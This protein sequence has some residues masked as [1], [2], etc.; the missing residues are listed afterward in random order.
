MLKGRGREIGTLNEL[1]DGVRDG[2]GHALVVRGEAGIGKT[3]LLEWA[4]T[5]AS[6]L[7]VMRATGAEFEMGLP[8]SGLHQLLGPLANRL[9]RLPEPQRDAL[10][11]A[12][13]R[14]SGSA[15]DQL[16]VAMAA[17]TLLSEIA[18]ERPVLC[19]VDD[20]QWL[21]VASGQALAFVARR[22]AAEP[23]G[24]LLGLR[25]P[26]SSTNLAP[27]P[28]LSVEGLADEEARAL[29]ATVIHGPMDERVRDRIISEAR[30]NPL[31]LLELTAGLRPGEMAGEF[32]L[33]VRGGTTDDLFQRRLADLPE[34][35][36]LLLLAAAAEPIGDPVLLWAAVRRLG[37]DV[38]AAA[39]AEDTGLIE[40]DAR[41]RFRHPLVRA[42]VYRSASPSQRRTVHA[43]LAEVTPDSDLDRRAWHQ[44]QASQGPD[45]AVAAGLAASAERA[46]TR[47]GVAAAAAF[48]ERSAQLTPDA[49]PRLER[50]FTAA[51]AKLDAGA[52]DEAETLLS[53]IDETALDQVAFA[54]LEIL[55]GQIAFAVRR[56]MDAPVPLLSAARRLESVNASM[57]REVH[58]DALFAAVIVGGDLTLAVDAAKAA[59]PADGP[60][61]TVDFLLD[62]LTLLLSGDNHGGATLIH[63]A[64]KEGDDAV[65]A[66]RI[67]M[68]P[69]LS[70]EVWDLSPYT[71]I[72][73]RQISNAR[74][75]GALTAL[76]QA[77]V[78][79]GG[80]LLR[81]G[82]LRT[83]ASL[84][85]QG[86]ELVV[87]TGT[88]P[89]YSHLTLAAWTG[90]S[91]TEEQIRVAIEDANVRGEGQM[92]AFAH[93]ALSLY[94]N[95]IGDYQGA[96]AAA[97]YATSHLDL[98]FKGLALRELVEAAVRA[99]APDVAAQA[100]I[101]LQ[102]GT[103]A[104][105]TDWGIG[106]EHL[107][108]ALITQGEKADEHYRT[109]LE[110]MGRSE[111]G[112]D[113]ARA[114]L[115]YGEWL[116]RE[117]RRSDARRVL[118]ASHEELAEMG[119]DGFAHR[120]A[121]EL[122][123]TGERARKRDT[124]T[125]D[126]LTAQEL[127]IARLVSSGS[128]SKEI[129][130]ELFISPR[131]VD[132]HLRNIFRKLSITSRRQLR[133]HSLKESV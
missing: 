36:Q 82:R 25:E 91:T 83:A 84:L 100:F 101:A 71:R 21:D 86:R 72:L 58:L 130:A 19:V 108:A 5:G 116:R 128:T 60:P 95:G 4:V 118:R 98:F 16:M 47:G 7:R 9:D 79:L 10:E 63:R 69:T 129:S 46:R 119:A 12:F 20:V 102:A 38:A 62:G 53:T 78:N 104:A 93:F 77:L 124:T 24:L 49:A 133:D 80:A 117:G 111:A 2:H 11:A 8:F 114:R 132:A 65:W 48:L 126:Q 89:G 85:E 123:A 109:A 61:S 17:L 115:L 28:S 39:P 14:R 64:L 44:A 81:M 87:A 56:G 122:N 96:L 13:G 92:V 51:R 15:P 26:A 68:V 6:G 30:G 54:R 31:A 67:P 120:A 29:L 121:R 66:R 22:I 113:L 35:T 106:T 76:P 23:I 125:V 41:V 107:C 110:T 127:A 3:A 73:N 88:A 131:T 34:P 43:A 50:T 42:T 97:Q 40:I 99:D 59:V 105:G 33:Q 112:G 94:R 74:E 37:L 1:V 57:A 52:P 27:L 45:E 75:T 90:Q 103:Q 32:G 55:R 70:V 18:E